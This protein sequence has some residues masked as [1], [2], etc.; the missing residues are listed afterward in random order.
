MGEKLFLY[1][2]FYFYKSNFFKNKINEFGSIE[3]TNYVIA[4]LHEELYYPH[5]GIGGLGRWHNRPRV[6]LCTNIHR[7]LQT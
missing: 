5:S 7:W 4:Q 2:K 3:C 1:W 6:R